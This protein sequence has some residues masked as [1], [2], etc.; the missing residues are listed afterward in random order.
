MPSNISVLQPEIIECK[1]EY[2]IRLMEENS[3]KNLIGFKWL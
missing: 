1:I 2:Y 3:I